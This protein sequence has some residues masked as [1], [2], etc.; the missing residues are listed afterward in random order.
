MSELKLQYNNHNVSNKN[1][2]AIAKLV[3]VK[4]LLSLLKCVV[5]SRRLFSLI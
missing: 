3:S 2:E 4:C 1:L 5:E